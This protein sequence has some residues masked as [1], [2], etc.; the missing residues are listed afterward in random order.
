MGIFKN[1]QKPATVKLPH[2]S[3]EKITPKETIM[4]EPT[5]KSVAA[6]AAPA[7]VKVAKIPGKQTTRDEKIKREVTYDIPVFNTL[8]Q[9][10][11]FNGEETVLR[12]FIE[13]FNLKYHGF[14][15]G[16]LAATKIVDGKDVPM[17]TDAEI[18][19]S[20]VGW[21]PGLPRQRSAG[22]A[23]ASVKLTSA[24]AKAAD[25]KNIKDPAEKAKAMEE[26]LALLNA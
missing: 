5:I 2:S 7:P 12:I 13:Q 26:L 3:E 9:A 20:L 8:A 17:F 22:G 19:Q 16:K 18:I 24:K 15:R 21:K 23:T 10:V 11:E 25:L 1:G 14:V 6:P 4:S